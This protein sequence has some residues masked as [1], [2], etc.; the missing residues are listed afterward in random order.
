MQGGDFVLI[1]GAY[2][3]NTAISIS[4]TGG[5]TWTTLTF[6][7][8]GTVLRTTLFYCLFNGTWSANPGISV[9][10]GKTNALS[11]IMHVFRG[12]DATTPLDVAQVVGNYAAPASPYDVTITGIT[13]VTNGAWGGRCLGLHRDHRADLDFTDC[14][15][16]ERRRNPVSQYDWHGH[17]HLCRLRTVSPAGASGNVTN[18]ESAAAEGTSHI[19]ALRPGTPPPV[20]VATAATNIQATSFSANWSTSTGATGYVLDVATDSGFTSFVT[21]Y[22][23]LIVNNVLT[24]PVTS[25]SAGTAYYYRVRAYSATGV[26]DNSN[27]ISL[28]TACA[29]PGIA[30]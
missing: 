29:G 14:R 28:T 23:D 13:T 2:R 15:L 3:G 8:R 25:L 10:A 4:E 20:P 26:S 22:R 12:V 19:L 9:A 7:Q 11:A 16:G 21:G 24:Y 1:I 30:V 27:T 6:S 5:Q 18:R 17:F